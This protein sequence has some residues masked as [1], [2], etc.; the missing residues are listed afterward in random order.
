MASG[1]R[2]MGF[3]IGISYEAGVKDERW[4][5]KAQMVAKEIFHEWKKSNIDIHKEFESN[6]AKNANIWKNR[7]N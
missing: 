7:N 3:A 6:Y 1:Q 5:D 4:K 2:K